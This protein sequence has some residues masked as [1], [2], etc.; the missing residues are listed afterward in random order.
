M[1]VFI[2]YFHYFLFLSPLVA[3]HHWFITAE[4]VERQQ[5][6]LQSGSVLTEWIQRALVVFQCCIQSL[7][8]LIDIGL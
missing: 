2:P 1:Q 3:N 7:Y 5:L 6:L 4:A 8:L